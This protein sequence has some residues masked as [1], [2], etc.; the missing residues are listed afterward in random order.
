MDDVKPEAFTATLA[1]R[2]GTLGALVTDRLAEKAREHGL[3]VKHVGVLAALAGSGPMSQLELARLMRVAPSLV[4][5]LADHLETMEAIQRL[6]DP[7]DRRRQRLELTETGRALLDE[8]TEAARALD[9]DLTASLDAEQ[10]ATLESLLAAV[11]AAE[12]LPA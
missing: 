4:V 5:T 7:D 9:D 10:R 2:I 6:R 12:G 11:A 3:K 1:F 8:C